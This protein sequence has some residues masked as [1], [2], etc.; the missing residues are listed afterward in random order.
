M[1]GDGSEQTGWNLLYLHVASR[2]RVPAG[3]WV[4]QD[5]R[6]GHPSCEGGTSTG[7][8]LHI[9]RKYNGEWVIADGPLPYVLSGWTVYA[10]EKPYEGKLVKGDKVITADLYAQSLAVVLRENDE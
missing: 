4:E 3:V 1:D 10:G 8:H 9:A 6:I 5:D 2:D 7:T